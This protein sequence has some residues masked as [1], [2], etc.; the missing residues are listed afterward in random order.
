M[1]IKRRKKVSARK[2]ALVVSLAVVGLILVC[3]TLSGFLL[4]SDTIAKGVW[5]VGTDLSGLTLEEAEAKLSESDDFKDLSVRADYNGQKII[6]LAEDINLTADIKKTAQ[7]AFDIGKSKN[8]IKNSCDYWTLLFSD[9]N[10]GYVPEADT[11]KLDKILYDFGVSVNGVFKDYEIEYLEDSVVISP[12]IPGQ[13]P[14][15]HEARE[16]I[17]Q[18]IE[19]GI[20]VDI[21]IT[22]KKAETE[23]ITEDELYKKLYA[24][25]TDAEYVYEGSEILVKEHIVGVEVQKKDMKDAQAKLNQGQSAKIMA[26]ITMPQVMADDLKSKLFNTTLASYSTSYSTG[27]VNRASNVALAASKING[28]IIKPGEVFS[29]NETIGDTTIANGYKVAPVFENGKTSEGV[30]GGICQVS[31][32]L[33]SA[34]LY[35]DLK[36]VERRNH[37]LTVAYVPKGQDATV[38]YGAIDFKFENN[39]AYPI[40]ISS[41]ASGGT[42]TVSLI[43]TKPDVEKTVHL[44]HTIVSTIQPTTNET[45]DPALP[46]DTKKVVSTGKT[47]YVVDTVKTVIENGVEKSSSRITRSTYKMVPTEISVGPVADVPASTTQSPAPTEDIPVEPTPVVTPQPTQVVRPTPAPVV[48]PEPGEITE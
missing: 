40:K 48:T 37:S 36:V 10:L 28:T 31:S 35:A 39:T 19:K 44:K 41:N 38:S 22:L 21:P 2:K 18:S 1:S 25:P 23:A 24:V 8:I 6:I 33:Y 5:V 15:T 13:N 32:T 29:Y 12:R 17:L 4:P 30:G 20:Y 47:G 26:K 42:I 3:F 27:A 14:D 34:V 9:I 11:E 45:L 7:K 46:A 43:G 16:A